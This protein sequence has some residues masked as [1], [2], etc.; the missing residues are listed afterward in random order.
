MSTRRSAKRRLVLASDVVLTRV[1]RIWVEVVGGRR[2]RREGRRLDPVTGRTNLD[3]HLRR[4]P[5]GDE[6][7]DRMQ[8]AL[9]RGV[10]E[11]TV[12]RE[13]ERVTGEAAEAS[14]AVL[15]RSAPQMLREHRADNRGFQRRLR[16]L[17]GPA[18]DALYEVYVCVEEWGS[19]LQQVHATDD[20]VPLVEALLG[21]HARSCLVLREVHAL[22]AQGFPLG[23]W[24]RTRSLHEGAVLA[25]LL[26][27]H[28]R[29]PGTEDLAERFLLHAVVDE[30]RDLNLAVKSGVKVDDEELAQSRAE[31]R[32]VMQRYGRMFAKDYGWAR[33][34]FPDLGP[35]DQVKFDELE[36]L[37]DTG[38]HR[39]HYRFGGHH[40]HSSA[41]TVELSSIGRAG[42]TYRVTGPTNVGLGPPGS[43]A[44]DASLI[45]TIA[46]VRGVTGCLATLDF[47]GVR[48]LRILT[49]RAQMLLTEGE[50]LVDKRE[51]RLEERLSRRS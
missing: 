26:S 44:L 4:G 21:L 37:A 8:D 25:T 20:D 5:T 40:V 43:V 13:F 41:W 1:E 9:D 10:P 19:N 22:M 6:F 15:R 11:E 18:L 46:V 42:K 2:R 16:A 38:L 24:A 35:K 50:M 27:Q 3:E 49:D 28:G 45:S 51:A 31:R 12:G 7:L 32:E 23:A 39:L 47:A 33:P 34:L 17:W 14:A 48:T 29:E 36:K 30:S